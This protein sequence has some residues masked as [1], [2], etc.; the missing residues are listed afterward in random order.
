[1]NRIFIL[2]LALACLA[3][4]GPQQTEVVLLKFSD[5][6]EE[7]CTTSYMQDMVYTQY[8]NYLLAESHGQEW[9]TGSNVWSFD[10]PHDSYYYCQIG[11]AVPGNC[12]TQTILNDA[13]TLTSP[14]FDIS[15]QDLTILYIPSLGGGNGGGKVVWADCFNNSADLYILIH[16]GGHAQGLMHGNAWSCPG[17]D[18]G[19]DFVH[20]PFTANAGCVWSEYGDPFTP[21]GFN[22]HQTHYSIWEQALLGWKQPSN[23]RLVETSSVVTITRS[24]LS[25]PSVQEI[26]IPLT[27][28]GS[29]YYTLEYKPEVGVLIRLKFDYLFGP[30][31]TAIVNGTYPDPWNHPLAITPTNPFHDP[32]RLIGVHLLSSDSMTATL[33]I[34]FNSGSS[35]PPPTHGRKKHVR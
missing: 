30:D 2:L 23:T 4:V 5:H 3:A 11:G 14:Y 25:T 29:Y 10:L 35:E 27:P 24:D 22:T 17:V 34:S 21:M 15:A 18:V 31:F 8:S 13:R 6:P 12:N 7:P 28:D 32:Y 16:E 33:D 26:R 19:E 1:M 9:L 20:A